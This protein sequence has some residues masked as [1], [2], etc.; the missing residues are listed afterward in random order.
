MSIPLT[1]NYPGFPDGITGRDLVKRIAEQAVRYGARIDNTEVLAVERVHGG[2]RC[3]TGNGMIKASAVILATG[4]MDVRPP[5][6][7][8]LHDAA[9]EAAL[10]RYCPI[11]DSLEVVGKRVAVFGRDGHA[12]REAMFVR[13]FTVDVTLLSWDG[14]TD[15]N[16]SQRSDLRQSGV[17]VIGDAVVSAHMLGGK[18]LLKNG[19]GEL[20][21]DAIY[22]ALGA[23]VASGIA[24]DLGAR[25]NEDGY[26]RVDEH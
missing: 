8:K 9:L 18:I 5:I 1:R 13:S 10:I 2:F 15:L 22:P 7:E 24:C 4:I 20:T 16:A 17:T 21:F 3:R 26:I 25:V 11:C 6:D 23:T 14:N 19:R 12:A